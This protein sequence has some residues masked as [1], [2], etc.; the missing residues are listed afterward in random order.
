[1]PGTY[2]DV[3]TFQMAARFGA[4]ATQDAATAPAKQKPGMHRAPWVR[5]LSIYETNFASR[6][7][8]VLFLKSLEIG[9]P[10]F[11]LAAA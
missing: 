9:Q 6:V 10:A 11:A 1:M 8:L 5:Q 2:A 3:L 7:M 4:F